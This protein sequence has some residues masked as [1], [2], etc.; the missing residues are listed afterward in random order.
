[1]VAEPVFQAHYLSEISVVF[2]PQG[3]T[4]EFRDAVQS[5]QF[6]PSAAVST[7][8]GGSKKSVWT[9]SGNPTWVCNVK[10]LQ[11]LDEQDSLVNY[12]L[13][14]AGE[15]HLVRFT[16]GGAASVQATLII[17]APPIG[18]DVDSWLDGTISMGVRG[19]PVVTGAA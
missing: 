15:A 12:L 18:G 2:D 5:F 6:V 3:A 11:D 17:A 8:K 1:M 7:T 9:A 16:P 13:A 14:H 4:L 10:F 19:V